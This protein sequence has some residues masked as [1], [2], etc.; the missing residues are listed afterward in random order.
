MLSQIVSLFAA[1]RLR[2]LPIRVFDVRDG[3]RA[4]ALLREGRHTGKVVLRVPQRFD[5]DGTVLISG[6]TGGRARGGCA[7]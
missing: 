4:C 3:Q 7:G 6:G 2:H 1:G 5:P